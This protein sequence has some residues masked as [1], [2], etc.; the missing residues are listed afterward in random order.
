[1]LGEDVT[2]QIDVEAN[3]KMPETTGS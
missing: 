1:M 2:V 3:M